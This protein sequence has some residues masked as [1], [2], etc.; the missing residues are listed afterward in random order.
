MECTELMACRLI[1]P[2]VDCDLNNLKRRLFYLCCIF[3]KMV[4]AANITAIQRYAETIAI[5]VWELNN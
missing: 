4:N 1:L 3:R 2:T 5:F